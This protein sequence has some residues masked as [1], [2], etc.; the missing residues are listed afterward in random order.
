MALT[1]R[2]AR[3]ET[4]AT[5]PGHPAIQ[6]A[7]SA[8]PQEVLRQCSS[9]KGGLAAQE[10]AARLQKSGPNVLPSRRVTWPVVLWRQVKN[11]LLILLVAAAVLS[12]VTG[13]QAN[14][15]IILVILLASVGLGFGNEWRAECQASA[16]HDRVSHTVVVLRGGAPVEVSVADL[17]VGDVVRVGLGVVVPADLRLLSSVDLSCDESVI[18]GESDAREKSVDPVSAG[19][20][21]EELS[22]ALMMGTV[23]H[24][25]S[26]EAVVVA[27][28]SD[29]VFGHIAA[30]LATE[31]PQTGFQKGLSKFSM[32]LLYVALALTAA[33]FV[34]NAILQRP[35]LD[36]LLYALA[37]A[38]GITPQ[39]LPAVVNT[40]QAAGAA[41]LAKKDVLVKRLACVEDLGNVDI[42]VTDK[43]GTL[44]QG[45]ID[46]CRSA[47]ARGHDQESLEL[48]GLLCC[49][50]DFTQPGAT[51]VGQNEIDRALSEH[52]APSVDLGG[53]RRLDL[54]PFDHVSRTSAVLNA[55][56][57]GRRVQVMKGAPESVISHCKEV[58]Q[59]DRDQ[60][61]ALFAEGL[62]TI[63]VAVRDAGNADELP[64]SLPS[65]FTLV[66]YLSFLD[67][68][69][70]DV[71]ASLRRLAELGVAVK[72][73][74]GDSLVVA[75]KVC[76]DL[77]LEVGTPLTG[78]DIDALGDDE[79]YDAVHHTALLAR[80][81]PEHKARIVQTLRRHHNV[82]FLGDGVNDAPAL[83]QA[84]VGIS[85]DTATD[86]AKDAADVVLL[87]K[88]LS[89]I[90]DGITG[91][92]RTFANTIKYVMMST[93]SNFGNMFS[94]AIASVV[95]PFLPMLS[96]QLLLNNLLY[97][98]S[99][100]AIPTD[101]VDEESLRKPAHW[102]LKGIRRFM[103]MF[104]P[105][106]SIFDFLTFALMLF[107]FHAGTTEF[108]AG[109]FVESLATQT[110]IVL[111]IRT[112]CI[113]FWRSRPSRTMVVSVSCV[114]CVGALIPYLP[115]A[116]ELGF[117]PLPLP[118]FAALVGI[119]GV[120]L[121]LIEIVKW[122][123]YRNADQ[124]EEPVEHHDT[125]ALPHS[126]VPSDV[127]HQRIVAGTA[128]RFWPKSQ[129]GRGVRSR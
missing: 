59:E 26:G 35:L 123:Y 15:S 54:R 78:E 87:K 124:A 67:Q 25:G 21:L 45:H 16:L 98:I 129:K 116:A 127:R 61:H 41:Q 40:S 51:P 42:L 32:F 102:D 117:A 3:S 118:F 119:V 121:V 100:L 90:V 7:A 66:G 31:L 8:S 72:V 94:A 9:Q 113:P 58:P 99:Q 84:D 80:V 47:P 76:H 107:V 44:T 74:T 55:D 33:I 71:E 5:G 120:Y 19:T 20:A 1:P 96:G 50:T 53:W 43:T 126:R 17:V 38:V 30:S 18:T 60:C 27:T 108:R 69:K 128:V 14:A 97:D 85:V 12:L 37:I 112:R 70:P 28:G 91:G 111:A 36:A 75:Q 63:A 52:V 2:Q 48:L 29:C 106:S 101:R 73:A 103:I 11:P 114:V 81:S 57:D 46:Y 64:D 22:C 122:F 56:G 109:W 125:S 115:F 24:S 23:V 39:L 89:V 77:G 34:G 13:D 83:H 95:L 4:P 68:P 93:S 82:A 104:G 92:R 62:R 79:L 105:V 86:V 65:D 88:D 6:R 110:L 49:E 10:A